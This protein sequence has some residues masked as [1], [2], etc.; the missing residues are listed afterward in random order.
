LLAINYLLRKN[1][2][3]TTYLGVNVS[4]EC[5]DDY[6]EVHQA[7]HLYTHILTHMDNCGLEKFVCALCRDYPGHQVVVSGPAVKCMCKQPPN[8]EIIAS[9]DTLKEFA[10][11]ISR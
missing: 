7:S 5:I 11:G 10:K 3:H 4:R 9:V 6:I 1:N 8:L 2:L